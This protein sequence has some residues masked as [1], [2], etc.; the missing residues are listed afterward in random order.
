MHI[1]YNNFIKLKKKVTAITYWIVSKSNILRV[2]RSK[3]RKQQVRLGKVQE[4]K[5]GRGLLLIKFNFVTDGPKK[6]H[7][8][9]SERKLNFL[10][11]YFCL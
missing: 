5:D 3:K 1:P 10:I 9:Y 4:Y 6:Q 8:Y 7:Q 2:V 11:L